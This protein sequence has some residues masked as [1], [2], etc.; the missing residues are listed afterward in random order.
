MSEVDWNKFKVETTDDGEVRIN[1]GGVAPFEVP[2]HTAIQL[3]ALLIKHAGVK[4]DDPAMKAINR[5]VQEAKRRTQSAL[6]AADVR[7]N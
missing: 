6:N 7:V 1:L 5:A 3:A 2:P 4:F